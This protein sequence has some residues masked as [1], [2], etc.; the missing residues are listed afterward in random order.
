MSSG[1]DVTLIDGSTVDSA[2]EA[3]RQ[4]CLVRYRHVLNMRRLGLHQRRDYLSNVERKE[5]SV[6]CAR[7]RDEF[8]I[9]WKDQRGRAA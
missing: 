1:N 5:G 3:W 7:L 2:S 4:E 6:A 9:D 8:A